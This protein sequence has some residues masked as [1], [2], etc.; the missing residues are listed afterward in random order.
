ML[1]VL[2]LMITPKAETQLRGWRRIRKLEQNHLAFGSDPSPAIGW[3]VLMVIA[4]TMSWF[5]GRNVTILALPSFALVFLTGGLGFHALLEGRGERA[6]GL[7][8]ILAGVVPV[9]AGSVLL[10]ISDRF[11]ASAIWLIGISPASA[12]VYASAT[13]LPY[14]EL[15]RD[16]ARALPRAFWFFQ[17]VALLITLRLIANLRRAR[18]AIAAKTELNEKSPSVGIKAED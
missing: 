10:A 7:A 6:V 18:Y 4:G 1:W 14:P 16:L 12:P 15:P 2:T 17:A 8:V 13:M 11:A 9:M 3:T 5:P